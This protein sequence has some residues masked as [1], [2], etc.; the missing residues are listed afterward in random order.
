MKDCNKLGV[1]LGYAEAEAEEK[2]PC[3][4]QNECN[5]DQLKL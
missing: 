5:A 2:C 1:S 3:M 4:K